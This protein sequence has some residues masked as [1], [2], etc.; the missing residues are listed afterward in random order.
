LLKALFLNV[1]LTNTSNS[2]DSE[3]MQVALNGNDEIIDIH[4]AG[5][6]MRFYIFATQEGR[7]VQVGCKRGQ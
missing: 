1:T 7:R 5:T 3:V 4:H 6:A 2:D